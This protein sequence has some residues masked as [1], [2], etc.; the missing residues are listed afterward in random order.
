MLTGSNKAMGLGKMK[1]QQGHYDK[2]IRGKEGEPFTD[3]EK[4]VI[5]MGVSM[6]LM[7]LQWLSTGYFLS[8][9]FP[10]CSYFEVGC[11]MVPF[12]DE[13]KFLVLSLD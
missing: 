10:K 7:V 12:K 8:A 2:V 1:E 13:T 9:F 6:K 4:T 5:S 11:V 3:T